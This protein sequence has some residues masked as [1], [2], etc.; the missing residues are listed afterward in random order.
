MGYIKSLLVFCNLT[1]LI[2]GC[3]VMEPP[4]RQAAGP[5]LDTSS[6][7]VAE[8]ERRLEAIER[9]LATGTLVELTKQ[10]D[11]LQR[12]AA[13]LR[14]RTEILEYNS[15]GATSRQRELYVDLDDRLRAIER[16]SAMEDGFQMDLP[17]TVPVDGPVQPVDSN[18]MAVPT[19][20]DKQKYDAALELIGQRRYREA[21]AAFQDFLSMFPQSQL[22]G[23]AQYWLAETYYSTRQFEQALT[24]FQIVLSNY[25]RSPKIPDAMLKV[26]YS[27]Y[28]LGR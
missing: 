21:G 13:D 1:L 6:I 14:G 19:G 23:N 2:T 16:R 10:V 17:N 20:T 8:I 4:A 12:Q 25:P 15:D 9:I 22:R 24:E 18:A 26:G 27:N 11:E 7:R 3:A 28:E 5:G